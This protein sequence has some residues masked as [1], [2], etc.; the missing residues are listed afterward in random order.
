MEPLATVLEERS[1]DL[2]HRYRYIKS[3]ASSGFQQY[4]TI[5]YLTDHGPQHCQ[6]VETNLSLL[7]PEAKK[8]ELYPEEIFLLL[9]SAHFH[10]VGLLVEKNEDESWKEIR[11]EHADRTYDYLHDYYEEWGLNKFEAYALKNICLG[12]S[13]DTLYDLPE[14]MTIHH[15]QVRIRFLAA[16]LRIAD[17]LDLDFT[18]VSR[19]IRQMRQIPE[20]SLR[21]WDKHEQVAGI[22]IAPV[23]WTIE[24]HVMPH[25][26]Q[27]RALVEEMVARK[28]QK[29][30][31]YVRPVF[32]QNGL[33]FRSVTVRYWDFGAKRAF[34]SGHPPNEDV[35][36]PSAGG[37]PPYKDVPSPGA[38]AHP[39]DASVH[40][41]DVY[42]SYEDGLRRL[43]DRMGQEHSRY[44]EALAYQH[45]L[46][47]NIA[48]CRR[49]GDTDTRKAERAA[50]IEQLNDLA[51]SLLSISFN[52]LCS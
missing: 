36:L 19:Y 4:Q 3:V 11:R 13:G 48:Q 35:S 18:R 29:E 40:P 52:E 47:E 27:G 6:T 7:L 38:S 46:T 8:H 32:E 15:D 42:S 2:A 10:D 16:L 50:I 30:L 41:P 44:S 26:D 51:L 20:G 22:R 33:Y 39:L 28:V 43:L 23:S 9:C 24:V 37:H 5:G 21:H 49:Y 31:D 12:H 1:P 14:V 25:N 17:E 34:A 45:R